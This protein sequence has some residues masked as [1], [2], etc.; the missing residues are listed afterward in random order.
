M[1]SSRGG[2][3]TIMNTSMPDWQARQRAYEKAAQLTAKATQSADEIRQ[4][5]LVSATIPPGGTIDGAL[6]FDDVKFD[7]AA[8]RFPIGKATFQFTFDRNAQ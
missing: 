3:M 6:D 2:D 5:A 1:N 7:Q 8:F 4:S